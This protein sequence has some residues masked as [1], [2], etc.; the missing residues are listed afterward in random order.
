MVGGIYFKG[1]LVEILPHFQG[2]ECTF[3][4]RV[5]KKLVGIWGV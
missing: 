3:G 4:G 5:L 2:K 1:K